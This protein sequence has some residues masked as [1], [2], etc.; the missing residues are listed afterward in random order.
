MSLS[1]ILLIISLLAIIGILATWQYVC[2]WSYC[3]VG[4]IDLIMQ[5]VV[6]LL[7]MSLIGNRIMDE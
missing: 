5:I 6:V 4:A 1:I 3:L 2:R 7:L